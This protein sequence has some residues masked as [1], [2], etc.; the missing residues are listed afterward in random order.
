MADSSTER[1]V[2]DEG[3]ALPR[4]DEDRV[5][6]WAGGPAMSTEYPVDSTFYP[7]CH[8]IGRHVGGCVHADGRPLVGQSIAEIRAKATTSGWVEDPPLTFRSERFAWPIR[9]T[10]DADEVVATSEFV[11]PKLPQV[12]TRRSG[13]SAIR[14]EAGSMAVETYPRADTLT[15]FQDEHVNALSV[16]W[17]DL[18][19]LIAVLQAARDGGR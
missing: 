14:H 8:G 2:P 3:A 12:T 15:I 19:D 7:C 17:T 5:P 6:S 11:R 16:E 10:V 9:F 1:A 18:D 13:V 4:S